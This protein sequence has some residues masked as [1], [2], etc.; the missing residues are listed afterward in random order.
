[1]WY[2]KIESFALGLKGLD[3]LFK[4]FR[5]ISLKHKKDAYIIRKHKKYI[6][7]RDNP[8]YFMT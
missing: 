7:N 1:M 3:L 2:T 4:K 6:V 5:F 8:N